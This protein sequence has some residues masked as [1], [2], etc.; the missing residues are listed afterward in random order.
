MTRPN[1]PPDA[2]D[3]PPR[4]KNVDLGFVF[5]ALIAVGGGVGVLLTRGLDRVIELLLHDVVLMAAL[6]P[7]IL[8]GV[9]L[10]AWLRL[11]IS[12]EAIA[13]WFG[14]AAGLVGLLRALG[15]GVVLP[16]GPMT[17]FPLVAA[18][19]RAGA[20]VGAASAFL[21]G[22][23]L[24]NA[25]RII[26]WEMAFLDAELVGW[27]VLLSLPFAL[28]LGFVALVLGRPRFEPTPK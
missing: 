9:L 23:M 27:R 4:R 15:A 22:W 12:R 2:E 19:G 11:L 14:R 28:A 26:V 13:R 3:A 20:D 7:K 25:N 6:A 8:A 1:H 10:A 21:G 5:L 24:L 16:G 18:F 17:A